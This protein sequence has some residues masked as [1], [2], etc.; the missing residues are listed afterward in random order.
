MIIYNGKKIAVKVVGSGGG[1]TTGT[2]IIVTT[3]DQ[4]NSILTN[5]TSADNGQVYKYTGATTSDYTQN[6]DSL[7]EV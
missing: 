6:A 3:A 7:L 4:M 2:P 5:A 1:G